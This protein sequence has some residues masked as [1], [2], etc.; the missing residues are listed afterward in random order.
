MLLGPTASTG[1]QPIASMG[2]DTPLAVLSNKPKHLYQYFKQIFAQVTNPALDCI[3][4]ELVTATET[5]LGSEGNLLDPGPQSCR[6]IRLDS[7]LHRQQAARPAPRGRA[8]RLQGHHPRR[9]FPA[10]QGG[11]GLDKSFS[12]LCAAA[13]KA[14]ADGCNLLIVSDRNIDAK[15]AAMPTLLVDGRPAPPPRALRHPH[16]GFHH[17]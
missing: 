5:F 3:R 4:E 16:P 2:N 15:N 6:M 11:K 12:A 13:D 9:L 7:P 14:I 10:D 1:V 17:P 8:R